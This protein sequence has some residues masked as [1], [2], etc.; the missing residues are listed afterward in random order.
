MGTR[1]DIIPDL[2]FWQHLSFLI[3]NTRLYVYT[4]DNIYNF[5]YSCGTYL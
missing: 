5:I 1:C 4:E 3:I 2:L